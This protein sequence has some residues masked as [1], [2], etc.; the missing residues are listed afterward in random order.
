M[1]VDLS[2]TN[3]IVLDRLEQE[4]T[5]RQ[6]IELQLSLGYDKRD[7]RVPLQKNFSHNVTSTHRYHFVHADRIQQ[8]YK[9]DDN[10]FEPVEA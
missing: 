1:K 4:H 8:K 3:V 10:L 9:L 2:I 5:M 6:L 7:V